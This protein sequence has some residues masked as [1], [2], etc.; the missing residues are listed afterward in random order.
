MSQ[1]G[2]N[3]ADK[4]FLFIFP[5]SVLG[6]RLINYPLEVLQNKFKELRKFM[7]Q[8]HACAWNVRP[9]DCQ[10]VPRTFEPCKVER[11]RVLRKAAQY[12]WKAR[13]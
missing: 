2:S 3:G 4:Y 5:D 1:F 8:I 13:C 9:P 10:T 6:F 7:Q 12:W 11:E